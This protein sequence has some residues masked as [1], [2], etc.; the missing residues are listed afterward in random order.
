[1]G[2][3]AAFMIG[4]ILGGLVGTLFMAV[5]QMEKEDSK[6]DPTRREL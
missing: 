6:N 5:F 2:A 4:L 1:M 3:I